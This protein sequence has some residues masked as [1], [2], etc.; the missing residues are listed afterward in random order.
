MFFKIVGLLVLVVVASAGQEGTKKRR[1]GSME[2][3]LIAG[4][5]ARHSRAEKAES[6]ADKQIHRLDQGGRFD[7]PR[8]VTVTK[9]AMPS[10]SSRPVSIMRA[11]WKEAQ[12]C[13][14]GT[15]VFGYIQLQKNGLA[16]IEAR[17]GEPNMACDRSTTPACRWIISGMEA[18]LG[19]QPYWQEYCPPNG[20][21]FMT[22]I[23]VY[24]CWKYG[25]VRMRGICDVPNWEST[26]AGKRGEE[27]PVEI[28][29]G[30][31]PKAAEKALYA[32]EE[33]AILRC[34]AGTAV[35]GLN[36]KVD[37]NPAF[38]Q[39]DTGINEIKIKCCPFPAGDWKQ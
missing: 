1:R 31:Q 34:P 27:K 7:N 28:M 8:T 10:P 35:C 6:H 5:L 17:C 14:V 21:K 23:Q 2:G 13:P 15:F 3:K 37:D 36:T 39:T 22:G 26:T 20:G 24:F 12:Y 9:H 11:V 30:D 38:F 25:A 33:G 4:K 19:N 18:G 16:R 32:W 29:L